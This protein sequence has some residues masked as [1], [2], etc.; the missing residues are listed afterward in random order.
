MRSGKPLFRMVTTTVVLM[1]PVIVTFAES[2]RDGQQGDPGLVPVHGNGTGGC[3]WTGTVLMGP[4]DLQTDEYDNGTTEGRLDSFSFGMEIWGYGWLYTAHGDNTDVACTL[5]RATSSFGRVTVARTQEC[6]TPVP[7][8]TCDWYPR[9]KAHSTVHEPSAVCHSAG[10][11][12]G[13]CNVLDVHVLVAGGAAATGTENDE[14]SVSFGSVSVSLN[15]AAGDANP[16]AGQDAGY[17][18]LG[19]TA[20]SAVFQCQQDSKVHFGGA[21]LLDWERECETWLWDS[22]PELDLHGECSSCGAFHF[23]TYGWTSP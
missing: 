23:V 6:E 16:Y 13:D 12:K 11:M 2:Q 22:F 4:C 7:V 5:T 17:D 15:A 1:F 14:Y 10:R 9:F 20:D 3:V 21:S 19:I 8:M 18:T